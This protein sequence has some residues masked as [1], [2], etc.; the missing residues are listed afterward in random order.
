MGTSDNFQALKAAESL[1]AD[2]LLVCQDGGFKR[3]LTVADLSV[4][5][6]AVASGAIRQGI[7]TT[8]VDGEDGTGT[9]DVQFNINGAAAGQVAG[10]MY[11]TQ[12]VGGFATGVT[13]SVAT[14]G[15][16][17][18]PNNAGDNSLYFFITDETGLLDLT[19]TAA[20]GDWYACF[21]GL[22]GTVL[23]SDVLT[24]TGNA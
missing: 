12:T 20:N 16:Q 2:T 5:V 6:T 10:M 19:L 8:A 18:T 3:K 11:F 13:T 7:V 23:T 14:A 1:S 22:D 24:I 21:V 9:L 4:L 15:G 17:L